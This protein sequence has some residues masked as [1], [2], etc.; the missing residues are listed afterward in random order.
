[1]ETVNGEHPLVRLLG[2]PPITV[3]VHEST[4]GQPLRDRELRSEGVGEAVACHFDV[5]WR[6]DRWLRTRGVLAELL[7]APWSLAGWLLEANGPL[8]ASVQPE[9]LTAIFLE[10]A[11]ADDALSAALGDGDRRFALTGVGEQSDR[12]TFV[13]R[14]LPAVFETGGRRP[15]FVRPDTVEGLAASI[16]LRAGF[17]TGFD[18]VRK[19]HWRLG[20]APESRAVEASSTLP[21]G[22]ATPGPVVLSPRSC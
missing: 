8:K 9:A 5:R 6:G 16:E 2:L 14:R 22:E 7:P 20:T 18:G 3:W 1:M 13:A 19:F 15:W 11:R 10:L 4:D 12:R 17:V 21:P